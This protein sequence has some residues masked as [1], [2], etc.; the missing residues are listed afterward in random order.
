MHKL[1]TSPTFLFILIFERTPAAVFSFYILQSCLY[2]KNLYNDEY[3][4]V[5][6]MVI[7]L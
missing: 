5:I 4:G 1:L 6:V 7:S 2:I 3:V